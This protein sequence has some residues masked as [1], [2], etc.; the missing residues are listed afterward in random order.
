VVIDSLSV[1]IA[2]GDRQL[3][4]AS[5]IAY[6]NAPVLAGNTLVADVERAYGIPLSTLGGFWQQG[7]IEFA[8]RYRSTDRSGISFVTENRARWR[9]DRASMYPRRKASTGEQF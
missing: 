9:V 2:R 4:E 8:Q 6:R 5:C 7:A 1:G 3:V